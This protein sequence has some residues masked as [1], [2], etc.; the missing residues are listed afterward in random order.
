MS[1][2]TAWEIRGAS[3]EMIIGDTHHP[4]DAVKGVFIIAHGFKGY[5]DYGMFPRL[6]QHAAANGYIAHRFNF[7]HSGMTNNIDTFERPDLFECDTW[8][9]QAYDLNCVMR[10]VQQG[11]LA[12][13][14]LPMILFGHSRG[15]VTVLLT[16]GRNVR[17][18]SAVAPAGIITAAAPDT[19]NSLTKDEAHALRR[20]GHIDS[21]SGRTG[22][23]LRV[24]SA[25]LQQQLDDPAGHDL[26]ALTANI[27][28]PILFVHGENDPTVPVQASEVLDNAAQR[29]QRRVVAGG[30]H[31]FNTP[32]PM[33]A[34]ATPSPQLQHLLDAMITFA[35]EVCPSV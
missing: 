1:Q 8:N 5:K 29:S 12:G 24:G 34:G 11:T 2:S 30:D 18:P 27:V 21:P 15:G 32:N 35:D 33:P 31:V 22:Q 10:A 25:F 14:G 17:D 28:S 9:T 26:L 4:V 7:S 19:C 16:A 3:G 23:V 6:A 13:Q 20:D